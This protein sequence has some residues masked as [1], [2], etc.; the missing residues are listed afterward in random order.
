[1]Y[2][3][4]IKLRN[5]G[6]IVDFEYRLPFDE[7]R[8]K[9]VV[10]VGK[11][12]SGKSTV[13]SFIVNS[14]ISM[15]Q[16]VFENVEVER[17]RVYRLRSPLNI[18][19]V[20]SFYFAKLEFDNDISMVEWQL[21]VKKSDFVNSELIQLA[22]QTWGA[23]PDS[24]SSCFS[25]QLQQFSDRGRLEQMLAENCLLFFPADRFE[26][27]D[28][29]NVDDLSSDLKLPEAERR[30]GRTSR[31]IIL[32][33][34]LKPTLDWVMSVIFDVLVSGYQEVGVPQEVV[35]EQHVPGLPTPVVIR[36]KVAH[37]AHTLYE[38]IAAILRKVICER[39]TDF[40]T[41]SLGERNSRI[42]SATVFRDG[43]PVRQI[44][45]LLSLSAGESALFCMFASILR[46]ADLAG[47][48]FAS[49]SEIKG[50]VIADEVDMHLHV[51]PQYRIF[52]ELISMFPNVQ[53]IIS[54]HA[55]MIPIGLQ[56]KLGDTGFEVVELPSGNSIVPE[57]YK[58]FREA[59]EAFSE[60][61]AF[62]DEILAIAKQSSR[63]LLVLLEGE[64]DPIYMRAAA[65]L[66][67]RDSILEGVDFEWIGAKD[68]KTGQGFHT[69]KD[70]LNLTLTVLKAKPEFV[71]APIVLLYDN[72]V[73]K[74]E[75]NFN[76]V[77]V[78]AMPL[79]SA[80]TVV[81]AGIEN[82]L[83]ET[84]LVDEMFDVKTSRKRNGSS[85]TSRTLN[86]MKLC[87]YLC[88]E[89]RDPTDFAQFSAVLDSIEAIVKPAVAPGAV[90]VNEAAT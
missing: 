60:T 74:V 44:R 14:L 64:T 73:N 9:P 85:T 1:M 66:L 72:D 68:P 30:R 15:K 12:G 84:V 63:K 38:L 26:P 11:N 18:N 35:Q 22:G 90:V 24:E 2:L 4:S 89:K 82:L 40:L 47:I 25:L 42:I 77:Y 48:S 76:N 55:P 80:N 88:Q 65:E 19:G 79:N 8:P 39:D 6:P 3:K 5:T 20:S 37:H 23:T 67:K 58:E 59:L 10:F 33:N 7:G 75:E 49:L 52:P 43:V 31:K 62:Q 27:P 17:G 87:T 78:R 71:S 13:I 21:N 57:A 69:G 53:F 51:G 86:K 54:A 32:K 34:R 41:L 61:K 83:P 70:A 56:A 29:L 36:F 28:W 46:D 16:V 45:D 81:E 50:I